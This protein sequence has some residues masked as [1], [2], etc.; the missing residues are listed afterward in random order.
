MKTLELKE[1]E[2][3]HGEGWTFLA[4]LYCASAIIGGVM[5]A[6]GTAGIGSSLA[7]AAIIYSC[8]GVAA[9]AIINE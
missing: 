8:G 7:G 6:A 9:A 4:G 1:M 3:I 2:A 5:L